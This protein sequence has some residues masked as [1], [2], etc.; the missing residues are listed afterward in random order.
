M[1]MII[2][3]YSTSKDF[4]E[5]KSNERSRINKR[6]FFVYLNFINHFR[7]FKK[8]NTELDL[9][10]QPGNGLL[11]PHI[12]TEDVTKGVNKARSKKIAERLFFIEL[13]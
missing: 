12:A 7:E 2:I 11:S 13:K 5:Q 9:G 8:Y 10:M 1:K 3:V 6:F 4:N